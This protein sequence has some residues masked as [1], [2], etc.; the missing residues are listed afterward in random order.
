VNHIASRQILSGIAFYGR[1]MRTWETSVSERLIS[2]F[3]ARRL[4]NSMR[5][6]G[7]GRENRVVRKLKPVE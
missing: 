3:M 7:H 1:R 2:L 6:L 5:L 4:A